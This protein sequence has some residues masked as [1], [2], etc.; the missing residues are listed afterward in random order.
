M[1]EKRG[2]NNEEKRTEKRRSEPVVLDRVDKTVAFVEKVQVPAPLDVFNQPE[3]IGPI[4]VWD[5]KHG[6]WGA[7]DSSLGEGASHAH[8]GATGAFGNRLEKSQRRNKTGKE[9]K[10][11]SGVKLDEAANARIINVQGSVRNTWE[12][13]VAMRI[14]GHKERIVGGRNTRKDEALRS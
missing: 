8:L 2:K 9:Q 3:R 1:S 10:T 7:G 6:A 14:V 5:P 4:A 12:D 13:A 11:N